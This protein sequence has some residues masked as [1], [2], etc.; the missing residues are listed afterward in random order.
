MGMIE[1]AGLLD[2]YLYLPIKKRIVGRELW[3]ENWGRELRK[4]NFK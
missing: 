2:A 4:K 3:E 1:I